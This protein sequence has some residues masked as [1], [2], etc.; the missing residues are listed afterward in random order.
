M[1]HVQVEG[2]LLD[3]A[4][5]DNGAATATLLNPLIGGEVQT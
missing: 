4:G 2:T 5:N 3:V 1:S